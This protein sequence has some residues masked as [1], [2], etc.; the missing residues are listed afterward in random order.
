MTAGSQILHMARSIDEEPREFLREVIGLV[1][2]LPT[3]CAWNVRC[4]DQPL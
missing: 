1:F 3:V 4:D 2:G